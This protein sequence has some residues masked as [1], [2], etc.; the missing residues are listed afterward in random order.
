MKAGSKRLAISLTVFTVIGIFSF[1]PCL[2]AQNDQAVAQGR[3]AIVEGTKQMVNGSKKI[4][5]V[6]E[7][8]GLAD[9]NVKALDKQ[10]QEGYDLVTKGDDMMA[11]GSMEQGRDM[12]RRGAHMILKAN[13]GV[14]AVVEKN[15]IAKECMI[16]LLACRNAAEKIR[17][18]ALQWYFGT[19]AI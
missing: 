10:M 5:T 8:K 2:H 15:G 16:P 1:A 6:L 4:M 12:M 3:K 17:H 7:K 14:E 18:G 13:T 11:G 19:T 9:A